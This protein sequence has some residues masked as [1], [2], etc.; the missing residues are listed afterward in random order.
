MLLEVKYMYAPHCVCW[1]NQWSVWLEGDTS[2]FAHMIKSCG[3]VVASPIAPT[4]LVPHL[5]FTFGTIS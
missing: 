1:R 4:I 5:W 3:I 2:E